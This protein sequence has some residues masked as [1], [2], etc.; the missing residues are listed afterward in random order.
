MSNLTQET[1]LPLQRGRGTAAKQLHIL[2]VVYFSA[3]TR[4]H[5]ACAESHYTIIHRLPPVKD[6]GESFVT[7]LDKAWISVPFDSVLF[8]FRQY[9]LF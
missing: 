5:T 4:G 6:I 3:E 2:N 9:S 7:T 8:A 1:H